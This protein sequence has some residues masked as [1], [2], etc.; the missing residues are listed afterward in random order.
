MDIKKKQQQLKE[1]AASLKGLSD[2]ELEA[3]EQEIIKKADEND[4]AVAKKEFKLP[5]V[6]YKI[7]AAG[8][9]SLLNKQTV[10]WQYTLGLLS[11]YERINFLERDFHYFLFFF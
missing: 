1:L 10:E 6:N 2:A 9:Q 5:T 4:A 3:R 7:V 11:M 8:I